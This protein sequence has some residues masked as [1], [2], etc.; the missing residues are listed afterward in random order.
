MTIYSLTYSFPDLEPVCCSIL[1]SNCFFLTCIQISHQ[2]GQVVWYSQFFKNFPQ[3]VVIHTVKGFGIVNKAKVDV[4]LELSTLLMIRQILVIW[5]LV[6]LPFLNPAL[7]SGILQLMYLLKPGLEN[8]KHYFTSMWD[9]WNCAVVWHC[10]SLGLEWK[11]TF[12]SLVA[13]AEFSRFGG[14]VS[15][16]LSQHHL[17][18]FEIAQLEFHHFH[19]LC[20]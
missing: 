18:G 3:F 20:S 5:S 7:T 15:A 6:P 19:H 17:S 13:N 9:E 16:A 2:A 4:F 12:S 1:T 8:F 10:L 11:L 14:I